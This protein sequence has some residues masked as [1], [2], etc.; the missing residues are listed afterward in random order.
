MYRFVLLILVGSCACLLA[1]RGGSNIGGRGGRADTV[2]AGSAD[3]QSVSVRGTAEF[4]NGEPAPADTLIELTCM[5]MGKMEEEVR[6]DGTFT[7]QFSAASPQA[8]IGPSSA[9]TNFGVEIDCRIQALLNGHYSPQGTV[10]GNETNG[11]FDAGTL[12]LYKKDGDVQGMTVSSTSLEAPK[13][14][15]KDYQK[16][17]Q[18]AAKKKWKDAIKQ[19]EKAVAAYPEYAEAWN[20]LGGIQ[21]IQK[22]NKDARASYEKS[23]AADSSYLPPAVRLALLDVQDGDWAQV[24][25]RTAEVLKLNPFEFPQAYLYNV[26]AN[27]QLDNLAEAEAMAKKAL[28]RNVQ[29]SYPQ[30]LHTFGMVLAAQGKLEDAITQYESFF[31][32]AP[33]HPDR[34]MAEQQL[35]I[36]RE[37]L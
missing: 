9:G 31:E 22:K 34:K 17:Q 36:I 32:T 35:A 23:L 2:G 20:A 21:Q 5:G 25:S 26:L 37:N 14:A 11:M 8:R 33:D 6:T 7:F 28:E 15:Q 12:R 10:F 29:A 27:L 16:G 24:S 18:A 1:Q 19:Y 30:L 13:G 3:R 4:E